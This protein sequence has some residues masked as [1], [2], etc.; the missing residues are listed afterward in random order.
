MT[1]LLSSAVTVVQ[2]H[3]LTP[4][5]K[6]MLLAARGVALWR[7]LTRS[8][9]LVH[10]A[11][12]STAAATQESLDEIRARIFGNHIGNGLRSGRKVLRKKLI[13]DKIASYYPEPIQKFDPMFVDQD[14]ERGAAAQALTPGACL[15]LPSQ[16]GRCPR[17]MSPRVCRRKKLK[18][19][20]LRRR[21]KAPPKK[22]Q[23][24]RASKKK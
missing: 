14:I 22:G 7:H 18:L 17:P 9:D 11:V 6:G 12:V 24:K 5:H 10:Q 15:H 2:S 16:P 4:S 21:G 1:L 20:K 19:D 8:T 3:E 23:G 13:G